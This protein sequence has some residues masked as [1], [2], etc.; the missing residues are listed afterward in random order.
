MAGQGQL[1]FGLDGI[2]QAQH[3]Q[4]YA[5][6]GQLADRR[7]RLVPARQEHRIEALV[8]GQPADPHLDLGDHPEA[9]FRA[10]HHFAQVGAGRRGREGGHL[11]R[12]GEGLQGAAGE[13]LLDAPVAQRLLATGAA[14]HPAAEGRQ[15]PRLRKMAE[16]VA[17]GTQLALH[18]RAAGA[19][20]EGGQAALLVEVEQAVHAL[21]RE[22][23]HRPGAGLRVDVP[24]HRG[25][26]AVGDDDH[27]L[28]GRPGQQLADLRGGFR[29]GHAVGER[30]EVALAHR[31]PVRQALAAGVAHAGLGIGADQRMSR[32]ARGRHLRQ[33]AGQAGVGQRLAGTDPCRQEGRAVRGQL[34]HRGLIAPTVPAPHGI[35]LCIF[36]CLY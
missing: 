1:G 35:L 14:G 18:L 17:A 16:C 34:H 13:Q 9:P 7:Q 30:A 31:Q 19:G 8:L 24:G 3:R 21:Q 6:L 15:L 33:H 22:G 12:P 29:K 4:R 10:K 20:A 27:V 36:S 28:R 26:A 32:Q 11:Q 25:A 23:Q 5:R 2:R